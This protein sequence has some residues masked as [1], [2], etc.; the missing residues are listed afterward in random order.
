MKEHRSSLYLTHAIIE[1]QV[2]DQGV[3]AFV[4]FEHGLVNGI[5]ISVIDSAKATLMSNKV[6]QRL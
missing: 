3:V 4:T 1:E 2:N 5:A 6:S